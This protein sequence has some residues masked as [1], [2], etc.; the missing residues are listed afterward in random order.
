MALL[1]SKRPFCNLP[2]HP[3]RSNNSSSSSSVVDVDHGAGP[4]TIGGEC[5][6]CGRRHGDVSRPAPGKALGW[7]RECGRMEVKEGQEVVAWRLYLDDSQEAFRRMAGIYSA[8][9]GADADCAGLEEAHNSLE[10]VQDYVA[11]RL[12]LTVK[13]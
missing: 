5:P 8:L 11:G 6:V 3:R 10:T 12:N 9:H 7:G 1:A 13:V 2:A 4:S